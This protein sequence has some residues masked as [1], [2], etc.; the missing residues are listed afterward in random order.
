MSAG[1]N[2]LVVSVLRVLLIRRGKIE[3]LPTLYEGQFSLLNVAVCDAAGCSGYII[4]YVPSLIVTDTRKD[5]VS[6]YSRIGT[7]MPLKFIV[8][9][10]TSTEFY[11]TFM[12]SSFH[13]CEGSR[14]AAAGMNRMSSFAPI[15]A[16][17]RKF[18]MASK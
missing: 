18:W 17:W 6:R 14:E 4:G 5:Q 12:T 15:H 16:H 9:E 11:R 2:L 8:V 3:K 7:S 10:C 13:I 1:K